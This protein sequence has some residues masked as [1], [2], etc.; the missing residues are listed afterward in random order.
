[1]ASQFDLLISKAHDLLNR[2]KSTP[3]AASRS[4]LDEVDYDLDLLID[5]IPEV[6]EDCVV[7]DESLMKL[8]QDNDANKNISSHN[9]H[10]N[11]SSSALEKA[12]SYCPSSSQTPTQ[13]IQPRYNKSVKSTKEKLYQTNNYLYMK[14]I[15][16]MSIPSSLHL[17][18]GDSKICKLQILMRQNRLC[19]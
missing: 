5:G 17:P 8:L 6:V 3:I 14:R 4:R 1:M 9:E 10:N 7:D 11:D 18:S 2:V 19:R 15:T 12:L 13:F 16:N